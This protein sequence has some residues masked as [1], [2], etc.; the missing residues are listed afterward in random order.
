MPFK[1]LDQS[2]P[3]LAL[4]LVLAAW[5]VVPVAI[6]RFARASF[7]ELQAPVTITASY[8][9]DL[10][11]YWSLRLH[12]NHELIEAGRDAAHVAASYAFAM[13]QN[14]ELESQISGAA[15]VSKVEGA[16]RR[17]GLVEPAQTTYVEIGRP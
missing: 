7:F 12:S 4:G 13:Q 8:A 10:Q 15:S 2:R 3:F 6:K 5:L 9:R 1:R 11:E 16:A 14:A 17:L